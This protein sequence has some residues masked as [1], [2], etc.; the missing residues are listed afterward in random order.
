MKLKILFAVLL[1]PALVFGQACPQNV[2]KA[3]PGAVVQC[4]SWIV[5]EPQMQ[6]FARTD[7]KLK[8]EETRGLTLE[9]LRVLDAQEVDFYKARADKLHKENQSLDNKRFWSNLGFFVL[10]IVLTGVAAKAAIESAK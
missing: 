2:T 8:V 3:K 7:D 6:D 10:G 4:D 1:V 9:K 5:S